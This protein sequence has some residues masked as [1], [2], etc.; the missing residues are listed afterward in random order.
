M[1]ASATSTSDEADETVHDILTGVQDSVWTLAAPEVYFTEEIDPKNRRKAGNPRVYVHEP[2]AEDTSPLS[3]IA[4]EN[5]REV[6]EVQVEVRTL[7]RSETK[8][9]KRDVVQILSDYANDNEQRTEFHRIRPISNEN[10][11]REHIAGT[12]SQYVATVTARLR[13]LSPAGVP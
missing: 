7:D 11:H 2:V 9:Y 1:P 13:A 3:G 6:A 8:Q 12:T 10:L 5:I 4:Y